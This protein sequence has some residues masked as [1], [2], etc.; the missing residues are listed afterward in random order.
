[1]EIPGIHGRCHQD[2]YGVHGDKRIIVNGGYHDAGDLTA[3][4]NTV[5]IVYA[6]LSLAD[7]LQQQG[8]DP[9]LSKRVIEESKWGFGLGPEDSLRRRLSH[10]RPIDQLLDERNHGRCGRS[11]RQ[12]D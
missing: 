12:R 1:M 5:D 2:C 6:L 3:T 4:G 7:R 10:H 8:L 11:F 9:E